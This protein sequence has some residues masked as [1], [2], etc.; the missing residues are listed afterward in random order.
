MS[1]ALEEGRL[2]QERERE[3][4]REREQ[5]QEGEQEQDQD[6]ELEYLQGFPDF[7]AM[8]CGELLNQ[9]V[10]GVFESR[11]SSETKPMNAE[12][13]YDCPLDADHLYHGFYYCAEH[14]QEHFGMR[15]M[16][17]IFEIPLMR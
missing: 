6:Q 10:V 12:S 5:E 15:C 7:F 14:F 17:L 8:D 1:T 9:D 11:F 4:E 3:R 16:N 13:C 2:E